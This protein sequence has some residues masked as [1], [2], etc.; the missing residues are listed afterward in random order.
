MKQTCYTACPLHSLP[1]GISFEDFDGGCEEQNALFSFLFVKIRTGKSN[2]ISPDLKYR[3]LLQSPL[4][5]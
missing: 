5:Y 2:N 3:M 1:F 4:Y